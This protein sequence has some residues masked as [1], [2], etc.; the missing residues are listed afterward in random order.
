MKTIVI[1]ELYA[2]AKQA[3]KNG[4]IAHITGDG[5]H[6]SG[7]MYHFTAKAF[8]PKTGKFVYLVISKSYRQQ[9][10]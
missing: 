10:W 4:R 2:W 9:T 1:N 5:N 3:R 7:E 8:N 6:Y